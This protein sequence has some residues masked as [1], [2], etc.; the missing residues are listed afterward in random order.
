[1]TPNQI[2][3]LRVGLAF[4]AVALFGRGTWSNLAAVGL[5]A[6]AIALDA[7]DGYLAR[8]K[9]L[10]TPLGAQLDILG[11]RIIEN[12]FF[13]YFAV[14]GLISVWVPVIFFVRG[15]LTDFA[16][17]LAAKSAPGGLDPQTFRKNWM[18]GSRWGRALV[19]SRASRAAYGV[20]KCICFCYLGVELMVSRVADGVASWSTV[21]GVAD[22]SGLRLGG[23]TLVAATVTFCLL[24]ALPV[25][26]EGRRYFALLVQQDPSGSGER[27]KAAVCPMHL[28]VVR[29]LPL[30][31]P[32]RRATRSFGAPHR[33]ASR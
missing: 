1:M 7:V 19:A 6:A 17:G 30:A 14:C 23:E 26:W 12:V 15:T 13:T 21:V 3:A 4:A 20:L 32:S 2:T 24:R 9:K 10:A 8:R 28:S 11:D 33:I 31:S 27:N 25:V 18:L 29:E 22:P 16:R 5:T